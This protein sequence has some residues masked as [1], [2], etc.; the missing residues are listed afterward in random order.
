MTCFLF[1]IKSLHQYV[2]PAAWY[3]HRRSMLLG[4]KRL[5]NL[6][7]QEKKVFPPLCTSVFI[8]TWQCPR[9]TS[10][11]QST[12]LLIPCRDFLLARKVS[13]V[14]WE[15][16]LVNL[17]VESCTYHTSISMRYHCMG[18]ASRKC[19]GHSSTHAIFLYCQNL[20]CVSSSRVPVLAN[21]Q[22]VLV[23]WI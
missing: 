15:V 11:K 13:H 20:D 22:W 23:H 19:N 3:S 17:W 21:L 4:I 18:I 2:R 8:R 6:L 10:Q 12:Q 14:R 7:F 1:P 9:A 5:W 16:F